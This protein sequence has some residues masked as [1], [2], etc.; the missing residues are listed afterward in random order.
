MD[1]VKKVFPNKDDETF[2]WNLMCSFLIVGNTHKIFPIFTGRGNSG[3]STLINLIRTV[4]RDYGVTIPPE[5]VSSSSGDPNGA[6]PAI[7][8]ATG[9]CLALAQEVPTDPELNTSV[10]NASWWV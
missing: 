6:T 8:V 1:Y 3:K 7:A 5:L 4:F 10:G 9:S 2:F